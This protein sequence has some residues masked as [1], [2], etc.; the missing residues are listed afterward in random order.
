[1]ASPTP[2]TSRDGNSSLSLSLLDASARSKA[3][4]LWKQIESTL[5]CR[6]LMC[7]SVWTETWLDHYGSK[8]PHSFAVGTRQGTPI[9]VALLTRGVGQF[10]GPLKLKTWHVGTAG[11]SDD[12]SVCVEFNSILASDDD[13]SE[14]LRLLV[15]W[16]Q[17]RSDW[18]EI[19]LDGFAWTDVSNLFE[20]D[21]T[22]TIIRKASR[23]FDLKEARDS[24]MEPINKLGGSTRSGIRR[25][26]KQMGRHVLEWAETTQQAESIFQDLVKLHQVRW[27]AVGKPGVY[28][29]RP[30]RDFHFDLISKLVPKGQMILFRV[31]NSHGVVGCSQSLV[32]AE[33]VLGYQGGWGVNPEI[34]SPGLL[35]D[36]LLIAEC[37][38]RGFAKYD[39]LAGETATKQRLSTHSS[40]LAW[41]VWRKPRWKFALL[42]GLRSLRTKMRRRDS[43][44]QPTDRTESTSP[45]P[46]HESKIEGKA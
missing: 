27:N 37:Q 38:K 25:G 35:V 36:Y 44:Q 24:A 16:M 11:E 22:C 1:M 4:E 41:I 21:S 12:D 2:L 26:L 9:A 19:R 17:A 8:I 20:E 46:T 30:F 39:F 32:D 14:F 15:D 42:N 3:I 34:S 45:S 7:S 6:R 29:S 31:S 43:H 28:A 33:R 5:S 18:D 10:D 13:Q 40:D 23:Y